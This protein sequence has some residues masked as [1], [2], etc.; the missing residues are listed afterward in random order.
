MKSKRRLVRLPIL[1]DVRVV[2]RRIGKR[3]PDLEGCRNGERFV[4]I[5]IERCGPDWRA[6]K[7]K[8]LRGGLNHVPVAG[9]EMAWEPFVTWRPVC[10]TR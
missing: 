10:S 9:S 1:I 5:V 3:G 7:E 6:A 2:L 8:Q 4:R